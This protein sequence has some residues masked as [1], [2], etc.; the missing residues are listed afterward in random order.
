[1]SGIEQTT[2][3]IHQILSD[4]VVQLGITTGV[5]ILLSKNM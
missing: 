3:A 5:T 2:Q 4:P 1:M